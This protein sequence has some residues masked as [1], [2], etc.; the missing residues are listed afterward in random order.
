[1]SIFVLDASY[2]L[3]WCFPDRATAA[4]DE[5]LRRLEAGADTAL[6]P[7]IWQLE[8][9]T[10]SAKRFARGKATLPR[11]IELWEELMLLPIRH[12][13]P[14][15]RAGARSACW[16]PLCCWSHAVDGICRL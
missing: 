15:R 2:A 16:A 5:T 3:T 12:E 11:V 6:V 4:A 9:A 1:V 14:A 13:A 10:L 8:S 7:W